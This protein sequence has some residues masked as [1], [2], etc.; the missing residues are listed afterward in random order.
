M[1]VDRHDPI[2]FGYIDAGRGERRNQEGIPTIAVINSFDAVLAVLN[3]EIRSQQPGGRGGARVDIAAAKPVVAHLHL[4]NHLHQ[5]LIQI[6]AALYEGQQRFV[7]GADGVPCQSVHVGVVEILLLHPPGLIEN[8]PPFL[9][10]IDQHFHI[11][12]IDR[13]RLD[14]LIGIRN[15]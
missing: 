12:H 8:L 2:A 1:T 11:A 6:F 10:R 7:A 14:F 3:L 9:T 13:L 4:A 15:F 5:Q